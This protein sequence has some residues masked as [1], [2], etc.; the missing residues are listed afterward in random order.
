MDVGIERSEMDGSE[1][2]VPEGCERRRASN[3]GAPILAQ[4]LG[5]EL[6]NIREK[7]R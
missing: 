6:K 1:R 3:V 5:I 2:D 4:G 7:P